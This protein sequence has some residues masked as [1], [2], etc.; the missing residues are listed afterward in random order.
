MV[1]GQRSLCCLRSHGFL[2]SSFL[3]KRSWY[4]FQSPSFRAAF[5]FCGLRAGTLRLRTESREAIAKDPVE[6]CER[7]LIEFAVS[8]RVEH[9]GGDA[10]SYS[11]RRF[12]FP[13][14]YYDPNCLRRIRQ[15]NQIH[16]ILLL[17]TGSNF[18]QFFNAY[19]LFYLSCLR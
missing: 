4:L 2:L 13:T 19:A 7:K 1:E 9:V 3:N 10:G 6:D 11:H 5:R 15:R 12:V 17:P 14:H 16:S 8:F 18:N